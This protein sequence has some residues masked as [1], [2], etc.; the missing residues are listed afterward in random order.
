VNRSPF[1]LGL[2]LLLVACGAEVKA[3]RA[4][5]PAKPVASAAAPDPEAWR[6]AR[7]A[8]GQRGE[9]RFPAPEVEKLKNGLTV[10]VVR[11]PAAAAT[12]RLVV[13]HGASSVPT[14]KSGLA[15]LTARL[16][17]ESTKSHDSLA[18]AEAAESLGA[19]LASD[20]GR[21]DAFVGLAALTGD[22]DR[23][24]SLLAEVTTSPAFDAKEFERVRA[25][26]VDGL[27]SERQ[28]P[29]R[30]ASLA[31]LRVLFGATHGAP[32]GGAVSDV[33]KLGVADLRAFH[34][35]AFRPE[36]AALLVVGDVGL[37]GVRPSI[38]RHFGRWKGKPGVTSEALVPVPPPPS[39]GRAITVVDR[40]GAVQTAVFAA[41]RFPARSAPGFEAR[42]VMSTLLGGLFTSR[43]NMNLREK[44]AYT[45]GAS[46]RAVATRN[47]GAFVVAT[48]VRTD[49]T[50]PAL[51]EAVRELERVRDPALGAPILAEEI[52]RAKADL[53]H[54]LGA[55]L[56][57]TSR[58][59]GAVSPLF[60]LDLGSDY[61]TRYPG[62]LAL[63]SP[64]EVASSALLLTPDDLV[65][66]LVGDLK[67]ISPGLEQ[68]GYKL[69]VA[70]EALTD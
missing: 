38:E 44:H 39:R 32:V 40:P 47:W 58:V 42:E 66:V 34:A 43:I 56:E 46:G 64:S 24:L 15:G 8:E 2:T 33:K 62:L 65:V 45:Y 4:R 17:I 68:Q 19:P 26:W 30:L 41:Q 67:A 61:L 49:A 31:G 5:P 60:S 1:V 52:D 23:G 48:S 69:E 13:R 36:N 63:V 10:Y 29:D 9:V 51:R 37:D 22:L 20:A 70:A 28:S 11:R 14:G 35:R 59:A 6:E 27:V 7:P 21:D 55:R 54:T 53:L 50:A 12:L 25:E 57:H 18:L 16:M 3:Y